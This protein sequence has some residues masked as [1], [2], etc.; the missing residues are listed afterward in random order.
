MDTTIASPA[1]ARLGPQ[2]RRRQLSAVVAPVGLLLAF[3]FVWQLIASRNTSLVPHPVDVWTKGFTNPEVRGRLWSAALQTVKEASAGLL[4]AT[5]IGVVLAVLM[6]RAKWFERAVFPWAV[7]L[8]TIPILALVPLIKARYGAGFSPRVIVCLIIAVF[9]IIT[10]SLFGLQSADENHH[11]LFT[12]HR[13]SGRRRL[14]KLQFPG[15]LP[16]MFTGLRIAAG[17]SVIGAIVGEYFFRSGDAGLG[18]LM[19]LYRAGRSD[20]D[21]EAL[22][23]TVITT[24]MLGVVVFL[25]FGWI[26]D[27][28]TRSWYEPASPAE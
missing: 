8:Q 23:A 27:R 28:A 3:V 9:P 12:L 16:A 15:A 10:N 13:A 20:Y 25:F 14:F 7:A 26:A 2:R 24:C 22:F 1:P 4:I 6:D 17:L 5:V 11:D 18:H 19:E 21:D